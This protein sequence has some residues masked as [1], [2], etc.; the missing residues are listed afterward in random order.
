MVKSF[1]FLVFVTVL[2]LVGIC[3][4]L[5]PS[6]VQAIAIKALNWGLPSKV[7]AIN[8]YMCLADKY[9]RSNQYLIALRMI[10]A[11]S[12]LCSIFLLWM[13]IKSLIKHDS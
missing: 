5:F 12:L 1:G 4:L 8:S 6:R 13:F 3:C 10:G 9:V 7:D 11:I 2:F